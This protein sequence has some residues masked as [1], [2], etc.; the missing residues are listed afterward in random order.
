VRTIVMLA[1]NL[2]MEV[3]AE[4]VEGETQLSQLTA[5]GCEYGQGYFFSRPKKAEPA[6]ALLANAKLN[7][8][9]RP[10]MHLLDAPPAVAASEMLLNLTTAGLE[11]ELTH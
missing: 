7:M 8:L 1:R 2:N 3:I 6:A 11:S 9:I 10:V 5:L 4:G